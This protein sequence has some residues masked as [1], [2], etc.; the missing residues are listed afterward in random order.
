MKQ[1]LHLLIIT[2]VFVIFGCSTQQLHH[3]GSR[4]LNRKALD[5]N[6]SDYIIWDAHDL[7]RFKEGTII[8]IVTNGVGTKVFKIINRSGDG[9]P[10]D[11]VRLSN[12]RSSSPNI[13]GIGIIDPNSDRDIYFQNEKVIGVQYIYPYSVNHDTYKPNQGMDLT[14]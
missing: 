6:T 2:I 1:L 13:I 4:P 11:D 9:T 3:T 8:E 7:T 12:Q 5:A 10:R 14:R